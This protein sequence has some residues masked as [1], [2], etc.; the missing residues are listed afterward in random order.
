MIEI[1]QFT[2]S[3]LLGEIGGQTGLFLGASI[4]SLI[5]IVYFIVF[6]IIKKCTRMKCEWLIT[7]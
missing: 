2:W 7:E 1:Q 3:N 6:I 4:Y 5:E